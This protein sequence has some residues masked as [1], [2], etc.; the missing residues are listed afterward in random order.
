ML[1]NF[2]QIYLKVDLKFSKIAALFQCYYISVIKLK[3]FIAHH[4]FD[5]R[6]CFYYIKQKQIY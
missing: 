6:F 5:T 2:M 1:T 4:S 3:K